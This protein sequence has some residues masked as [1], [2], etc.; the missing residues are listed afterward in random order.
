[1]TGV[2]IHVRVNA[3]VNGI[4]TFFQH[5]IH[6]INY[7]SVGTANQF[8]I[9]KQPG[10]PGHQVTA[11]GIVTK[12]HLAVNAVAILIHTSLEMV[13]IRLYA[14][15]QQEQQKLAQDALY[16]FVPGHVIQSH[17][18]F[19]QMQVRIE[20][21]GRAVAVHH[22]LKQPVV[23]LPVAGSR[24][25]I[26]AVCI[27]HM[28]LHQAER[29]HSHFQRFGLVECVV[30]FRHGID[31]ERL[32]VGALFHL[33]GNPVAGQHPE[34]SAVFLVP[35]V[36]ANILIGTV[37]QFP[38]LFIM[39]VFPAHGKGPQHPAV[40]HDGFGIGLVRSQI[41]VYLAIEATFFLIYHIVTPEGQNVFANVLLHSRFQIQH[42]FLSL[43]M[44]ASFLLYY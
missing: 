6:N 44:Y 24:I 26:A 4:D 15:I 21:L 11:L 41:L 37:S 5:M 35:E 40:E 42:F 33:T 31:D 10:C 39:E 25:C 27:M 32:A 1:M 22:P 17:G 28:V 2:D 43:H 19:K 14:Y 30:V 29:F 13:P 16:I 18:G 7:D 20:Q 12:V 23:H 3:A 36:I 38:A 8:F 9:A 34:R